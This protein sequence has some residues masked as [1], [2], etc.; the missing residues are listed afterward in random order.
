MQIPHI[1]EYMIDNL[2]KFC[3]YCRKMTFGDKNRIQKEITE[4][5]R[6]NRLKQLEE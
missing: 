3:V 4:V 5:R 6:F 1:K 2:V